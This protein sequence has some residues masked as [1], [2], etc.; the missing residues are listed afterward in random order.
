MNAD[1]SNRSYLTDGINPALSPDGKRIAFAAHRDG[2]WEIYVMNLDGSSQTPLT[3]NSVN[4]E[5]PEWSP[6][7]RRITFSSHRDGNSEIYVMNEDGSSQ[8]R[9]THNTVENLGSSWLPDGERISFTEN[10]DIYTISPDGSGLTLLID[11]DNYYISPRWS[12]DGRRIAVGVEAYGGWQLY[13]M[14]ADGSGLTRLTDGETWE[15][16]Y[17]GPSPRWSPDG[18]RIAFASERDAPPAIYVINSDGSGRTRLTSTGRFILNLSWGSVPVGTSLPDLVVSDF[19]AYFDTSHSGRRCRLDGETVEIFTIVEATITNIGSGDAGPFEIALFGYTRKIENLGAGESIH[20]NE[21]LPSAGY[22]VG[23]DVDAYD[24][25]GE[26]DEQNN[27][28]EAFVP[29]PTAPP[30]C[31]PTPTFSRTGH[32]T[33]THTN[34]PTNTPTPTL[35]VHP[36]ITPTHTYTPTPTPTL[37]PTPTPTPTFTPTVTPTPTI[38]P[39]PTPTPS[40]MPT[41]TQDSEENGPEREPPWW[42]TSSALVVWALLAIVAIVVAGFWAVSRAGRQRSGA[43]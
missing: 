41:P 36:T 6:D 10:G 25:V 13:V 7:G 33:S 29:I 21:R 40:P 30:R 8:T 15:T 9:L 4:D 34:T 16:L 14:Y 28:Q 27:T 2:D 24:D 5:R 31:T 43:N 3:D 1:G 37:T 39:T 17:V 20:L 19:S 32:P 23:V 42:L 26:L 35:T 38:S 11:D 22:L 12:P 18:Q